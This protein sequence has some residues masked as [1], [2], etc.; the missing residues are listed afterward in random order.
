MQKWVG[1]RIPE[2]A[3]EKTEGECRQHLREART[4]REVKLSWSPGLRDEYGTW[5]GRQAKRAGAN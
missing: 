1:E 4:L 3:R 5:Q 2:S